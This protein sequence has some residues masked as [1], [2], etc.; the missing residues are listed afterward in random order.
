MLVVLAHFVESHRIGPRRN[1]RY[2]EH[3]VVPEHPV[4][5]L[6]KNNGRKIGVVRIANGEAAVSGV[7]HNSPRRELDFHLGARFSALWTQAG[8]GRTRLMGQRHSA[9]EADRKE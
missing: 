4:V 7:P 3:D 9:E 2:L 1:V 5:H 6:Y 8:I